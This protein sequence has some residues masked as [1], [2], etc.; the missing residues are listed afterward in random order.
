[1]NPLHTS[2]R[3][4]A[5]LASRIS[6]CIAAG[7]LAG[8]SIDIAMAADA[9]TPSHSA[10]PDPL[11]SG[12]WVW[13]AKYVSDA[14]EQDQMLD[15]CQRQGFNRLLVQIPWKPGTAQVVHP[16]PDQETAG[17]AVHPEINYSD[18]LG[19]LVTEA[20][21][22]HIA[23]EA[24]DGAPYMGDKI[25]WPETLA[26]VDAILAFNATLPA[27][28]KLAGIHWDIEPYVRPDWKVME[29]R[30]QIELDYLQLLTDA[31][32]KLADSGSNL[33]LSVDIPMWYDNK[34]DPA[35]NCIVTFNGQ[36]KNFHQHIQDI[37]DYVGIMSYRQKALGK[38]S[39]SEHVANEL[40]YAERI[41]KYVVPAF[42]TI[43]L[44]D[45][46]QI[47]FFGKDAQTLLGER[48]KLIDTLKDRPGFGGMFIHNYPSVK[49][50]L[51]PAT[52]ATN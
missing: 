50:I 37:C 30:P 12:M 20:A 28:A 2:R 47:T 1:M 21:K 3:L 15:F 16:K 31:K 32:K 23:I 9:T 33:T 27:D 7:A 25:H 49:A 38:N 41:G 17:A 24:L 52:A 8:G 26:T 5:C 45:T 6:L 11:I 51:E 14:G 40:A 36:T 13:Q 48:A 4:M 44:K 35:D 34:T 22:R 39:T 19:R 10:R 18:G 43:Q 29:T 46:P 42:E